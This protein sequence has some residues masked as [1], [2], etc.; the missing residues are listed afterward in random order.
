MGVLIHMSKAKFAVAACLPFLLLACGGKPEATGNNVAE[1]ETEAPV[2]LKVPAGS[3]KLE[4]SHASLIWSIGHMGM[5]DYTARF[6]SFDATVTLDPENLE[7]S[8]VTLTIDPASV[9]TDY[10]LDY[11]ALHADS[12][13]ASWDEDIAQDPGKLAAADGAKISFVSTGVKQTGPRTA[14]VMGNLTMRGQ[15][16]PV[17]MKA[18]FNGAMESHPFMKKPVI[19]FNAEG[20]FKPSEFGVNLLG[21]ALADEVTVRFSG[22]FLQEP[23]AEAGA[24]S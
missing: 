11:K 10:P 15:T 9:H 19:G 24:A 17:T 22:E 6:A 13:Y 8:A 14:D 4:P 23:D 20:S 18:T 5:S 7:N 1:A 21:G 12:A 16:K 3:Y 2:E